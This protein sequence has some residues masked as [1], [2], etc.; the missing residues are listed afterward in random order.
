[1][2]DTGPKFSTAYKHYG[3]AVMSV[4]HGLL[5]VDRGVMKLLLQPIKEDLRLTDT[6]LGLV[7]GIAFGFFYATLG[8]PISRWADR[9]N[10]VTI[11]S[12][13]IGLW[14]A[15]VMGTVFVASYVQ[16][17]LARMMAAVGESGCAPPTYSLLGDY[18]PGKAERT[19]AMSIYL[20]ASGLATLIS[21]LAAG[22][23]NERYG[24]RM[25]FFLMGIPGLVMALVVRLTLIEPRTFTA[26]AR[27]GARSAP[28]LSSTVAKLWGMRSY[29][30]LT[31][32][33]ILLYTM[34]LGLAPWY[35]AFMIRTHE[36]GTAELG[37]WLGLLFSVFSTA[38][39]L[40]GGHLAARWFP[41]DEAGQ[42][43]MSAIAIALIVPCYV[44]F[45]TVPNK[46]HALIILMPLL[47]SASI[48]FAPTYA[49][50][51]RLVGDDMRATALAFM[52]L[53]AN[54]IGMG[55]GPQLVGLLSDAFMPRFGSDSLRY[56]LLLMSFVGLW[57]AYYFWKVARSIEEDL[58]VSLKEVPQ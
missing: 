33:L 20:T 43:R 50:L 15:T 11:A 57:A 27:E 34:S 24:W 42:M 51:Q 8:L 6:Q 5:Y 30:N 12:L 26:S 18:F 4:I 7:T 19:R 39:F 31:M 40:L 14:G 54:L 56:A 37:V 32:A 17:L 38:G 21:F 52:M 9:G 36:M 41:D 1:M 55:I 28:S 35:A 22:W 2:Y 49:L 47:L 25:T 13:A 10:R 29:R 3:L 53:L 44:G 58:A 16:L 48:C 45:F 46:Y 23:L